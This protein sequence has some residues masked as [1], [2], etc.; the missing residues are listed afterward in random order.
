MIRSKTGPDLLSVRV[1]CLGNKLL[2]TLSRSCLRHTLSISDGGR[3]LGIG[4]W[5]VG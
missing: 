1:G 5:L 2:Q 4:H 3:H